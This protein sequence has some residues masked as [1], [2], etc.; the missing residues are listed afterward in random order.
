MVLV[1]I[2]T[3]QLLT[4]NLFDLLIMNEVLVGIL[5]YGMEFLDDV[6]QQVGIGHAGLIFF[7]FAFHIKRKGNDDEN[8]YK[9]YKVFLN[10]IK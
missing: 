3:T 2:P 1:H 9:F 6:I 7:P 8:T 4:I 5:L 10:S